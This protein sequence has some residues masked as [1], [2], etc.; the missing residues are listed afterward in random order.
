MSTQDDLIKRLQDIAAQVRWG[1]FGKGDE[2]DAEAFWC[3]LCGAVSVVHNLLFG[4]ATAK[5][6]KGE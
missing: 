1:N 2:L 6:A 5:Y 3:A 4:R